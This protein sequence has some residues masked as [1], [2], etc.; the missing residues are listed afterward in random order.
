METPTPGLTLTENPVEPAPGLVL[1]ERPKAP[2]QN[3]VE[4]TRFEE[5]NRCHDIAICSPERS[6]ANK[7]RGERMMPV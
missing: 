2:A 3:S 1:T 5:E 4:E 6:N 7:T